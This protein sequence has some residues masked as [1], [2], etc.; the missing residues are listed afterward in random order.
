MKI[1]D[2]ILFIIFDTIIHILVVKWEIK[3]DKN[4]FIDLEV[5]PFFER[6]KK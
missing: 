1:I 5:R 4:L 3:T 2:F 6:K